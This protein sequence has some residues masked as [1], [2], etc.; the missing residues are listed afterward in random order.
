MCNTSCK[1][2][3]SNCLPVLELKMYD[4]RLPRQGLTL[5]SIGTLH[6]KN[7]IRL[8]LSALA[9]LFFG[10]MV[11]DTTARAGLLACAIGMGLL[12]VGTLY[13]PFMKL[14]DEKKEPEAKKD[15]AQTELSTH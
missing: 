3:I 14:L 10:W 8:Q 15:M 2:Q 11:N 13:L 9:A 7:G 4:P 12:T 1:R 5:Q 6:L